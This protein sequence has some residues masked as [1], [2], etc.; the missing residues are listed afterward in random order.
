MDT[1]DDEDD[2]DGSMS[3]MHFA[4]ALVWKIIGHGRTNRTV[5]YAYALY[6][7]LSVCSIRSTEMAERA[8][9]SPRITEECTKSV[10][11]HSN[12]LRNVS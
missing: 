1:Y 8:V 3:V 2:N 5:C 4:N 7:C 9:M 12:S 10:T 6:V 11:H